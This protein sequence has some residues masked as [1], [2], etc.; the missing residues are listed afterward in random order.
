[1]EV[2]LIILLSLCAI[3]SVKSLLPLLFP[4]STSKK[5]GSKGKL[6]PGPS[7][8][9]FIG[10]LLLI[11]KSAV[12]LRSAI[13][14]LSHKYGPILTLYV[15]SKPAI[16][17]T[18]YSIA[19]QALVRNSVAFANRP[20][21]VPVSTVLSNKRKDI[22]G[23]PYGPT[24][25]TLR[26]NFVSEVVHPTRI[27][28]YSVE[29]KRALEAMIKSF[30]QSSS[31]KEPI[32]LLDHIQKAIYSMFILMTFGDLGE[33]TIRE[34][35]DIQYKLL[36]NYKHFSVFGT[37]PR[38]GKLVYRNRYKTYMKFL[39]IQYDLL[40]PV[41][42]ARRKL[43]QEKGEE[44]DL[45]P[46][47][48]TLFDLQIPGEE[49]TLAEADVLSL[50]SELV[51]AGADT[52]IT[53]LQWVMANL[54]KYPR[55]QAKLYAAIREVVGPDAKEVTEDDMHKV[56]YLKAVVMECLRIHPPSTSLVPHT[57]ME[58]VELCGYTIP[59]DTMAIVVTSLIGRDP[60]VWEDPMDFR[61]ERLIN[62]EGT[63]GEEVSDVTAYKMMPFGAGRRMCAGNRLGLLLMEYFVA[64]LVLNFE[65]KA[66]D[67]E[68]VDL[69][70]REEF[71]VVMKNPV[72]AHVSPRIKH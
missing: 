60:N 61:P 52:S 26:R 68:G 37:W 49:G 36:V 5:N 27:R 51:N 22:G 63:S 46:Y 33:S 3:F 14:N 71:L 40:F 32:R 53:M 19:H 44:L 57:V 11:P 30:N 12:E 45:V 10:N 58:D 7:P 8:L 42:R 24:W 16:F 56:T 65:W 25:R 69:S 39:E 47:I 4:S 9:P 59:K 17:I 43:K 28:S 29:R 55:V 21:V 66:V 41:I 13:C 23:S 6:P 38:L 67:G 50:C 64:N 34:I 72:R 18:S 48:D 1:M 70:E 62:N 31:Q 35:E 20:P 54:V 15:G 2:W